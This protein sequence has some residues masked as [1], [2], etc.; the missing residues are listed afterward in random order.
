MSLENEIKNIL[1]EIVKEIN[2]L[3]DQLVRNQEELVLGSLS[4]KE[5]NKDI[6]TSKA[7]QLQTELA[8]RS[9]ANEI[10]I[11]EKE[12]ENILFEIGKEIRI[13]K[14]EE[15]KFIIEIDYEKYV[16]QIL[17]LIKLGDS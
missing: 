13:H 3:A 8:Q 4:F 11:L 9:I 2:K 14:L 16:S 12:I 7:A 15:G 5:V 1:F 6:A 17:S 10:E